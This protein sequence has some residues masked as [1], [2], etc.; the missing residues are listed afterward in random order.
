MGALHLYQ[1]WS[2][3]NEHTHIGTDMEEILVY[4]VNKNHSS[5]P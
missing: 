1:A 2:L 4:L 3:Q 5:L